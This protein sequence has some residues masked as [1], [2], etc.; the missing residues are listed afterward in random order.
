[1]STSYHC[2]PRYAEPVAELLNRGKISQS[3]GMVLGQMR[4]RDQLLYLE[5]AQRMTLNDFEELVRGL[6]RSKSDAL[7]GD[8]P[9]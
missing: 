6:P 1:M 3:I 8:L 9:T 2:D 5:D 7:Q 4:K